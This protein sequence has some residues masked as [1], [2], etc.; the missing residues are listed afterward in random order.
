M[1]EATHSAIGAGMYPGFFLF[2]ITCGFNSFGSSTRIPL[3]ASIF[4]SDSL[5]RPRTSGRNDSKEW[6]TKKKEKRENN[7]GDLPLPT[8]SLKMALSPHGMACPAVYLLQ[9]PY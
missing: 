1:F 2:T 4:G 3:A 5:I 6:K 7:H 8:F 9:S